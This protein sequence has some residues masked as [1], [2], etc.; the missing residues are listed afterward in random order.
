M[1]LVDTSLTACK[2][3][4]SALNEIAHRLPED[5]LANPISLKGHLAWI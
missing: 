3:C 1:S 2:V 5:F 4:E